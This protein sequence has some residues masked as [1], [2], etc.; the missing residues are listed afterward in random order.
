MRIRLSLCSRVIELLLRYVSDYGYVCTV[1]TDRI[2][3]IVFL[4]TFA[5]NLRF[6]KKWLHR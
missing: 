4:Q 6:E 1:Y 5:I 3:T 2:L